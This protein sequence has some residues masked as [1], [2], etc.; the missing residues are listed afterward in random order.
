MNRLPV[1]LH[2]DVP[3]DE[4]LADPAEQPSLSA[5]IAN[6]LL[7]QSPYH[8]LYAHPRLECPR[9]ASD[10]DDSTQASNIGSVA[11]AIL[12]EGDDSIM[13]V[14][15]ADTFR[16]KVAREARDAALA[17]G[18]YPV[19]ATRVADVR[20]M[21]DVARSYI[22][23][24]QIAGVLDEGDP[25]L[26][27][28]WQDDRDIWCRAR[29]DWLTAD[30]GFLLHLKTTAGSAQP[31][32]WIRSQLGSMG[33]DLAYAFY[34]SGAAILIGRQPE[35]AFL[36]QEQWPP[37]CCSLIGLAP[38]Y[39][40]LAEQKRRRALALWARYLTRPPTEWPAYPAQIAYAEPKPWNLTD[41]EERVANSSFDVDERQA[42][43]GL[44]I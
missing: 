14:I 33:Y 38:M 8:A 30:R 35:S 27:M 25:E 9:Y 22:A 13:Q 1:G 4:Y 19:L 10:D 26:T 32:Q 44:Q 36:V 41:F 12:L 5:S 29:P 42:R 15:D 11:H 34:A 7:T 16:S 37:Y 31:D 28:V 40:D 21:A 18:R 24:S 39:M 17:E 2:P 23:R 43:D 20:N 6:A 3:M